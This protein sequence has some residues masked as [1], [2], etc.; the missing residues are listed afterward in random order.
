MCKNPLLSNPP[1]R[2][3]RPAVQRRY[4]IDNLLGGSAFFGRV[5]GPHTHDAIRQARPKPFNS[6]VRIEVGVIDHLSLHLRHDVADSA[7]KVKPLQ[8]KE[9]APAC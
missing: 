3:E 2:P 1:L 5:K 6:R 7:E 4:P 8:V 9:E